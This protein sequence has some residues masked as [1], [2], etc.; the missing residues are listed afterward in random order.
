MRS[1]L[2]SHSHVPE[3][4]PD[5]FTCLFLCSPAAS[6]AAAA[7]HTAALLPYSDRTCCCAVC[8]LADS[9]A[10]SPHEASDSCST[11]C[12]LILPLCLLC[13]QT[14]PAALPAPSAASARRS[15]LR[16][17]C[18]LFQGSLL[19]LQLHDLSAQLIQLGRHGIQ[20]CLD[21]CTRLIDQVDGLIRQE[22]VGNVTV[23]QCRRC[24]QRSCL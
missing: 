7:R 11:E 10:R 23:G 18:L 22:P 5:L 19:D 4:D 1:H 24:H 13:C 14:R 21:Q 17:I 16:L 8:D 9:T 3:H 2:L 12:F 20:L 6:A 15:L